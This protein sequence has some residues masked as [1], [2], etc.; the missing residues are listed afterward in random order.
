MPG[1]LQHFA[2]SKLKEILQAAD[3]ETHFAVKLREIPQGP[4]VT[5]DYVVRESSTKLDEIMGEPCLNKRIEFKYEKMSN[6]TGNVF[7]EFRQTSD[8]GCTFKKSGWLKAIDDGCILCVQL[9]ANR[10]CPYL[11]FDEA[12][13]EVLLN[14]AFRQTRTTR[15]SNG[16]PLTLH[17]WGHLIKTHLALAAAKYAFCVS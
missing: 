9:H 13:F 6:K 14:S 12:A 1:I 3:F 10:E 5:G 2:E 4:G 7:C 15:C 11:L 8:A 17:Q 16:N